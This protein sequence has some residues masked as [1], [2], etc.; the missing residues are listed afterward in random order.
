MSKQV[1]F[2]RTQGNLEHAV[3]FAETLSCIP[4]NAS[5]SRGD[6]TQTRAIHEALAASH[7]GLFGW[8]ELVTHDTAA[9]PLQLSRAQKKGLE[10]SNAFAC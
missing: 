10:C 6:L 7:P 2:I 8:S 5:V 9:I 3:F 1:F 4:K